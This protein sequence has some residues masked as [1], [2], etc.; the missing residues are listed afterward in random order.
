MVFPRPTVSDE[1]LQALK[2]EL[3]ARKHYFPNSL[4]SSYPQIF[5]F[6]P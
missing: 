5:N 4:L 6:P 2:A 3:N 1:K